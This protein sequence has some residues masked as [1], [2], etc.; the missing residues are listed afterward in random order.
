MISSFKECHQRIKQDSRTSIEEPGYLQMVQRDFLKPPLALMICIKVC[1][2]STAKNFMSPDIL[3]RAL[4]ASSGRK[5]AFKALDEN[6]FNWI[7]IQ[8]YRDTWKNI[9]QQISMNELH[10]HQGF[11]NLRRLPWLPNLQRSF[12]RQKL[13][14]VSISKTSYSTTKALV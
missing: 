9:D 7:K 10:Q 5:L 14:S 2:L 1:N 12:N 4:W 8:F 11:Q 6:F 13:A 3:R